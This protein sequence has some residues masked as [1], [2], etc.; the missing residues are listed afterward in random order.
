MK[1]LFLLDKNV[2]VYAGKLEDQKGEFSLT[3]LHLLIEIF[4]IC[5]GLTLNENLREE[6][7][8][9][10]SRLKNLSFTLPKIFH[11][12]L[13]SQDKVE[14]IENVSPL[15]D[16]DKSDLKDDALEY[17]RIANHTG[18]VL[19]TMNQDLIDALKSIS[20]GAC[21]P[22]ELLQQ[23]RFEEYAE[24][25]SE[26]EILISKENVTEDELQKFFEQNP[27]FIDPSVKK[28][29]PE[30]SLGGERFP[31]FV[32]VLH[33]SNYLAV[34]IEKPTDKLYTRGGDPTKEFAH[35]EQQ[36]RDYLQWIREDKEYLRKRGFEDLTS[37]NLRGL[38]IMGSSKDLSSEEKRKLETHNSAVSS[39]HQIKTFDQILEEHKQLLNN[40]LE[41]NK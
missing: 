27:I 20:L 16:E 30:K 38:L 35:A 7:F 19:V 2:L 15:P 39:S 24:L 8:K 21:S 6:Y 34:E 36:V 11:E 23:L 33:D 9:L 17:A 3:C 5:L 32:A 10:I 1:R 13:N 12:A 29:F 25:I 31:D 40:L 22:E 28:L 41:L 4:E 26:Y 14:F 37:E 18:A